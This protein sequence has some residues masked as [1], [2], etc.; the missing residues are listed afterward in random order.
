[1]FI[2]IS[3]IVIHP[4]IKFLQQNKT[5]KILNNKERYSEVANSR[6]SPIPGHF[7]AFYVISFKGNQ[8]KKLYTHI[9]HELWG[10]LSLT[11]EIY[12]KLT[13]TNHPRNELKNQALSRWRFLPGMG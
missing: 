1:M 4:N 11:I 3:Y 6:S 2:I 7:N 5:L 10:F 13:S 9:N 12:L 8:K